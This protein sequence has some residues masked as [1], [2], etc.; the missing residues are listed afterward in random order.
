MKNATVPHRKTLKETRTPYRASQSRARATAT[1]DIA[2]PQSVL[3]AAEQLAQKMNLSLS[4]LHTAALA[5]YLA[6]YQPE[7]V[8]GLLNRVY[9][10][11]ASEMDP[12]LIR[13]QSIMLADEAW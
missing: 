8:T 12:V 6:A 3:K 1:T 13:L 11:E 10:A 5:A 4:E 2:V 9:K 7:N